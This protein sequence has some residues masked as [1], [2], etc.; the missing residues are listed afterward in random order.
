[1]VLASWLVRHPPLPSIYPTMRG[2]L[3][4]LPHVVSGAPSLLAEAGVA[5]RCQVVGGSFFESVPEDGD[6]YLLKWIIHD[7]DDERAIAILTTCRRAM[8]GKG[9]LLVVD[10]VLPR[11]AEPSAADAFMVDLE[12]L[13]VAPGGRERTE[14]DFRAVLRA[15]GFGLNRIVPTTWMRLGVIEGFLA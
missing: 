1:M 8:K 2:V 10:Q 12:M 3:F 6:A 9:K 4:D 15:A 11:R 14:E 5:G 13:V 7:W